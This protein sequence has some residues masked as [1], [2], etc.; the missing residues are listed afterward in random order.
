[1]T[2]QCS[3]AEIDAMVRRRYGA[4]DTSAMRAQRR[5][6]QRA[7]TRQALRFIGLGLVAGAVLLLIAR[8]L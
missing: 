5:R 1:M 4:V 8:A 7:E 3:R 2:G 6:R